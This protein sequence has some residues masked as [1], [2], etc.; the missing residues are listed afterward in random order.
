MSMHVAF[1][2]AYDPRS[3]YQVSLPPLGIGYLSS[4]LKQKCWFVETSFHHTA[5]ELIDAKPDIIAVSSTTE[6]FRHATDL[7]R[8]AK[9]TL[10]K[11][12]IGGGMHITSLPHTLPDVYDLGVVGEGEQTIVEIIN[13]YNS[14]SNP[15]PEDFKKLKGVV[16]HEDGRVV[17]STPQD[18]IREM[19]EM[20]YPDR[21]MIDHGWKVP[22]WDTVH[23]VSS[24]G[25]PYKCSFCSSSLHWKRFRFFSPE[26]V[27]KEIEYLRNRYNPQ[28]LYF[29]DDLFV[30]HIGRWREV[31]K[32]FKERRIHEGVRFRAYAR[33]DLITQQMADEFA[34]LNFQYID[35]GFE[36]NSEPVL[37][38]L[39][40]TRVTPEVNQRAIDMLAKNNL[41]IGANFI[42]GSPPETLEMAEE[43]YQFALKNRDHIERCSV[44]PLQPLPGTG[45][46]NYAKSKGIV[47]DNFEWS[48][49]GVTY[50]TFSWDTFPFLGESVSRE[51]FWN[52]WTKFHHLAKEINYVGQIRG[53][54]YQ[55]GQKEQKLRKLEQELKT[56]QGSRLVKVASKIRDIKQGL[57]GKPV[58]V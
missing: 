8:I 9:E 43:T 53:I 24:R 30:G 39:T 21:D 38:F 37:K 50:D 25:C 11:P 55:N 54:A 19:D 45:V 52:F 3:P 10:G 48:R 13:L 1:I 29:F 15:G 7:A 4:Y 23:L 17:M 31:V 33:V 35:F 47:S 14:V 42:I 2:T 28:T 27:A 44:G 26:Y 51:D 57:F 32:L 34:D 36:S 46:W 40:K 12:V 22:N 58:E 49:L 6:N 16:Y 5:E 56:L 18:L 20:P 41:S